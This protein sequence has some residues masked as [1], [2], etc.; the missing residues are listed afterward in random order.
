MK[1]THP[2]M[3]A[4]IALLIAILLYV[5]SGINDKALQQHTYNA[6]GNLSQLGLHLKSIEDT[7]ALA[8][9][10]A[11]DTNGNEIKYCGLEEI[12][13]KGAETLKATMKLNLVSAAYF[14]K[15]SKRDDDLDAFIAKNGT[16]LMT[17]RMHSKFWKM[18]EN[19]QQQGTHID[20]FPIL[21]EKDAS[22]YG[23]RAIFL[24]WDGSRRTLTEIEFKICLERAS[25]WLIDE[26]KKLP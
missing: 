26:Q 18:I 21:W 12:R 25:R 15:Y 6:L 3:F 16:S 7:N 13:T 19:A 11:T 17:W 23:G 24:N 14:A 4:L 8:A 2:M 9:I 10:F 22:L 1:R 5:R 20:C